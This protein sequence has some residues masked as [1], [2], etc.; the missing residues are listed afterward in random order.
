MAIERTITD[1]DDWFIGEDKTFPT[2]IYQSDYAVDPLTGIVTGTLQDITG[3]TLSWLVKRKATDLD[4]AALITKTTSSGIALTTPA[5]GLCTITVADTDTD[6][7]A[8]GTYHHELKRMD[9]GYEAIL[10][11]GRAVLRGAV[12]RT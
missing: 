7:I 8:A 4:A 5:S 10:I 11:Q 2:T 6:S 1:D 12:H 3:W 9:A